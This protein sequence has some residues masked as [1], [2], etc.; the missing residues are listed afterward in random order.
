MSKQG[1]LC[2]HM[3]STDFA[4]AQKGKQHKNIIYKPKAIQQQ[5]NA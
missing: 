3:P 4:H 5:M 1:Q 2:L